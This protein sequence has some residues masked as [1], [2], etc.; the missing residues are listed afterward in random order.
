MRKI[1]ILGFGTVGTGAVES[2]YYHKD[3]I[4]K[5]AGETD[6]KYILDIRDFPESPYKDKVIH[7][8]SLIENDPEIAVAAELMGGTNP[9]LDFTK[10][11]LKKGISVVTSNKELVARHGAELISLAKAN[12]CSY[13][14]EASTGGAIP[15]I[16]TLGDSLSANVIYKIQGI[17]N[18]TTNFILTK[19]LE[20]QMTF[21]D[22][23]KLAQDLGYAEK[24]PTD[25][26]SGADS[27]R[28]IC[29]L[30]SLAFGKHIKP[31]WVRTVGIDRVTK[32]DMAY[33]ESIGAK[34]KLVAVASK[35]P[36]SEKIFITVEPHLVC[37]NHQLSVVSDVFNAVMVD[38][39]SAG[40]LMFYGRGAGKLPTAS[41]VLTDVCAAL[42]ADGSL[43]NDVWEDCE[44]D[45]II[46]TD[47]QE[48]LPI[49][50]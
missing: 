18:G 11:L 38:A 7:D 14:F 46:K 35:E 50:E 42:T 31:E 15:I 49:L 27:A 29:I 16:R 30:A 9:A 32:E 26:I 10:R 21:S 36:D 12:G 5:R 34:I 2:F 4:E 37:N 39:S 45:I 1:A 20:E 23:L 17:L 24:D 44:E 28:K 43:N 13:L 48:G 19:M 41:A 8:F 22:A 40:R 6:I 33:A 47:G 25:D 3:L